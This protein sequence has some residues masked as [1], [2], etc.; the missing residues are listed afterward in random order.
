[1]GRSFLYRPA[2]WQ[3]VIIVFYC[4][5][6]PFSC[7]Y[8]T[9]FRSGEHS[10]ISLLLM[11]PAPNPIVWHQNFCGSST[12]CIRPSGLLNKASVIYFRVVPKVPKRGGK[13]KK[14][15]K[16]PIFGILETKILQNSPNTW[17]ALMPVWKVSNVVQVSYLWSPTMIIFLNINLQGRDT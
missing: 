16:I 8:W 9:L 14:K 12:K 11:Q 4:Y 10:R 13:C 7:L 3:Y 6:A 1:M 17:F 2:M 5:E 15:V